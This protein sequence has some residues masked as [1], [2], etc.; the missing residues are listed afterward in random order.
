MKTKIFSLLMVAIAMVAS[1]SAFAQPNVADA[2]RTSV[3]TA[4]DGSTVTYSVTGSGDFTWALTPA[5]GTTNPGTNDLT[6]VTGQD[7]NNV[8][9]TWDKADAGDKYNL[10]VYL[11]DANGCYSELYRF[12]ITIESV[13][14]TITDADSETC[15]WLASAS[16]LGSGTAAADYN[17]EI[18]FT[19]QTNADGAQTPITVN[20]SITAT[21]VDSSGTDINATGSDSV[22]LTSN[23]GTLSVAINNNFVNT[24][25]SPVTYTITITSATDNS[26]NPISI[27]T[28]KTAT[29]TVHSVP[30][31]T[32]N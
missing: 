9:I 7:G 18:E 14:L 13:I 27:G 31:I 16:G 5:T 1:L 19:V 24:S 10:D 20:Y 15:S 23:S 8:S 25:G 3:R 12:E 11:V 4:K 17:D 30:T 26:G 22:D 21:D 28:N 29:I 2:S 6:T 32:L